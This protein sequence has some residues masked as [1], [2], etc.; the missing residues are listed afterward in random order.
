MGFVEW[1]A[2]VGQLAF[3]KSASLGVRRGVHICGCE[4]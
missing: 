1:E 2:Y 4:Y 3:M